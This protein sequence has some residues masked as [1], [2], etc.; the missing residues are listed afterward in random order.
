MGD[1][2]SELDA[3]RLKATQAALD[4]PSTATAAG[5]RGRSLPLKVQ[6][7]INA[8]NAADPEEQLQSALDLDEAEATL[9]DVLAA[10]AASSSE[11]GQEKV[12]RERAF[13]LLNVHDHDLALWS[14][15]QQNEAAE[16]LYALLGAER[17]QAR[18]APDEGK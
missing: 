7:I 2:R 3:Q 1:S 18:T 6:A 14:E 16:V 13:R 11:R 15:D 4:H 10:L 17:G 9:K 5:D 8:I 12:L